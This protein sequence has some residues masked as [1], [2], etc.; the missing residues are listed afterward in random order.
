MRI[1][2]SAILGSFLTIIMLGCVC[3]GEDEVVGTRKELLTAHTWKISEAK[4]N[5]AADQSDLSQYR[6]K[7][8]LSGSYATTEANGTNKAG[9][10]IFNDDATKAIL[11]DGDSGAVLEFVLVKLTNSELKVTFTLIVL[12]EWTLVPA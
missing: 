2:D 1:I 3:C 12:F 9:T 11:T 5:G 6:I 4:V 7:F 10:W 8:N